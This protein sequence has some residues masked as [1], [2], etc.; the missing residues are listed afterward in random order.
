MTEAALELLLSPEDEDLRSRSRIIPRSGHVRA[1]VQMYHA[2]TG[3]RGRRRIYKTIM[4]RVLGRTI[5]RGEY[6]DH[7]DGNPLNN[8]RDNL[9]IATAR[10][11]AAN[12]AKRQGSKSQYRGVWPYGAGGKWRA[13]GSRPVPG[14]KRKYERVSLGVYR[15]EWE[16]ALAYNTYALLEYGEFA[17][18][19]VLSD[20]HE[21]QL[22][23][24][25]GV[26]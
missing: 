22:V 11:N 1:G 12:S 18:L 26:F 13:A 24:G 16:A 6:I 7:I 8:R 2:V 15:Y 23:D 17:R 9:R 20:E 10:Q 21:R 19:N 14:K 25:G 4:R 3:R 5:R